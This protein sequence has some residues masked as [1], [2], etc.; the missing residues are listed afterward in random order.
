MNIETAIVAYLNAHPEISDRAGRR[1]YP[2]TI[3]QTAERPCYAYQAISQ[4]E[5][6]DHDGLAKLRTVRV[7]FTCQAA[8]YL[9]AKEL[10]K[11]LGDALRGYKGMMGG[12]D[13]LYVESGEVLNEFDGWGAISGVYTTRVDVGLMYRSQDTPGWILLED[14][15]G[16][17][18]FEDIV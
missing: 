4:T 1:G 10:A 13:G 11:A 5:I 12:G 17:L 3:P 7:Q 6:M 16:F 2:M 9:Q 8:S 18:L 15:D 14:Q